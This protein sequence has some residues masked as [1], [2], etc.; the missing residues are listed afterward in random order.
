MK[1]AEAFGRKEVREYETEAED[2][3]LA[4]KIHDLAYDKV[5]SIAKAGSAKHERSASFTEL[6]DEIKAGYSEEELEEIGDMISKYYYKAEKAAVRDLPLMKDFVWM[7]EKPMK[8]DR[9]GAR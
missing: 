6:K 4:K 8:Y 9:Y 1:L 7:V 5:Y 2:E 3:D